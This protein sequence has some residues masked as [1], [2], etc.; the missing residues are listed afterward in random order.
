M[1]IRRLD[2]F[3]DAKFQ[4]FYEVTE[5]AEAFE[6][7]HHS[8]WSL[9]EAKLEFRRQDPTERAEAWAAYDEGTMVGGAS[10]W[11]PLLDNLTKCW[12]ALGVDP[13]HRRRGIGSALIRQ[14]CTR[15]K[16]EGRTTMVT[17]SAYPF[18]RREDHPYRLFAQANGFTVAIDEIL[19]ILPL[20]A[21][22]DML[23]SLVHEAAPHHTAYRIESFVNH[24]PGG[25]LASYCALR[26]QLGVD[27]PT[28]DVDFEAESM[29]PQLWLD[30]IAQEKD[31]GRIRLTTLATD[32]AGN[33]VA[34]TDLI[35]PPAPS[36]DVWQWGTLVHRDHR[37][38]RLGMAVK[39]ANL[40]QLAAADSGRVRIL[41][42]NAETNHYMVD[43]NIRLGFEAIEVCPMMELKIENAVAAPT[44]QRAQVSAATT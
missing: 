5:R 43:I 4:R 10:L 22:P 32:D 37:G 24:L 28:G 7:P 35:L 30:R 18:E 39:V 12:S 36:P 20:P 17:E 2:V 23:Q 38:H 42:C 3:D 19:R 34:Y 29:T 25:L 11:F 21:D 31:L 16:Q 13:D 8:S 41:T 40:Q 14:I 26:N 6:R 9:D 44:E 1:D 27:A 33:V 15:M